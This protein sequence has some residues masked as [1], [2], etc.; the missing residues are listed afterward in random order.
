M[1]WPAHA[2]HPP[3]VGAWD[4][5]AR[6]TFATALRKIA[7]EGGGRVKENM[8]VRLTF[9]LIAI[10]GLPMEVAAM[11]GARVWSPID[12]LTAHGHYQLVPGRFEPTVQSD[13]LRLFG[14]GVGGLG[15][16]LTGFEWADSAWSIRWVHRYDSNNISTFPSSAS[17]APIVFWKSQIDQP[18]GSSARDVL[19]NSYQVGD[20]LATPDTIAIVPQT[21][22]LYS[23]A[24]TSRR[25]WAAAWDGLNGSRLRV[26]ERDRGG[27]AWQAYDTVMV[28][29]SYSFYT[30]YCAPANDTTA[31]IVAA[32][33]G[34]RW[35]HFSGGRWTPGGELSPWVDGAMPGPLRPAEFGYWVVWTSGDRDVHLARY[36][37]G[38]ISAWRD[39]V[40][41][42][43]PPSLY[44]VTDAVDVSQD[45]RPRP[46][47]AWMAY[48]D[49]G[50]ERLYVSWPN[51]DGW[52]TAEAV[53]QARAG[54]HQ[55]VARDEN[56]DVWLAWFSYY[57][58]GICWTHTY[59]AAVCDTPV[60]GED[61]GRPKLTWTLDRDAN[62]TWWT[63]WRS[64][65][66]GEFERIARLEA[67]ADRTMSHVDPT[68]PTGVTLRYR[69]RRECKDVR[70]QWTSAESEWLPRETRLALSLLTRNPAT[71]FV[72][73]EVLGAVAGELVLQLH[74]LQGR[75][76]AS[77]RSVASGSGRD[78][79]RLD[80]GSG[81]GSLRPGV[82]L[83]RVRSADGRISRGMKLAVVR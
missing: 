8:Q 41:A 67:G 64:E 56:G 53:P 29:Y 80:L 16:Y 58:W 35:G 52:D 70:Y 28:V 19:L 57:G 22:F 66:G 7:G 32:G 4:V 72:E 78:A 5:S 60:V 17:E 73:A 10:V 31:L 46:V 42:S 39:T 27:G 45:P 38:S 11:P 51:A 55:R 82:Y 36:E 21:T 61:H 83:L 76:V 65:N 3:S 13:T 18:G 34:V 77:R 14:T 47:L 6:A 37:N 26:F 74:D 33:Q 81:Q 15:E 20:S 63:V 48:G 69:V 12:T 68:A 75:V 79:L 44:E 59:T 49:D 40:T 25:L 1:G 54:G 62:E 2:A 9:L 30:V 43:Y 50:V 24:A 71:E 23:G